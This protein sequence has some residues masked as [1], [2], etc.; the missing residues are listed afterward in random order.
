MLVDPIDF[1]IDH[2]CAVIL[3]I[4]GGGDPTPRKH[5]TGAYAIGHFGMGECLP[6]GSSFDGTDAAWHQ[7]PDLDA[8]DRYFGSYGVCDSP[9]QFMTHPI[10]QWIAGSDRGF[11]VSF[12]CIR[13]AGQPEDGGWRWHKWGEYIGE[14]SPQCE[15]LYDEGPEIEEVYVYH[16]YECLDPSK[17]VAP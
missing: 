15:Y 9:E 7:Y 13:K 5:A 12:T 3:S 8:G 14:K 2:H 4:I 10:G 11:T 6:G 1:V 16:V 17:A